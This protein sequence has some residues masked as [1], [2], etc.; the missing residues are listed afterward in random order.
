MLTLRTLSALALAL[1][2]ATPALAQSVT[3][4]LHGSSRFLEGCYDPCDCALVA[5]E[6][7]TGLFDLEFANSTPDGF[8]HYDVE[9]VAWTLVLPDGPV[10]VTG[11][12]TYS[13]GGQFALTQRLQLI[14]T[15]G[16]AGPEHFDSGFVLGGISF[17]VI[18]A[19]AA[20]NDFVCYDRVFDL[21]AAPLSIGAS[22]CTAAPNS[23][24]PGATL[25]AVGNP[26]VAANDFG[27][28]AQG[29]PPQLFGLFFIG[30]SPTQLPLGEG[31]LCAGGSLFRLPPPLQSD[32]DGNKARTVDLTLPPATGLLVP[33]STRYF[34]YWYRDPAG[35]PA[36]FNLSDGVAVSFL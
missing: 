18:D 6:D 28:L 4:E 7:L 3:Y 8:D 19:A 34:Q 25:T 9:N 21:N 1:A 14:L 5:Y 35:G 20:M 36:G 30:T 2:G 32:P 10:L 26:V 16:S 12:G 17:P 31:F 23:V 11:A 33:G 15:V 27:L 29:V 13:I 24:G 22:Y